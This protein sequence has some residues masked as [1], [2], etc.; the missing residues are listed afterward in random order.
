[1]MTAEVQERLDP[2][3]RRCREA[4][5][6]LHSTVAALRQDGATWVQIGV[7]LGVTPQAVQQRF[8]AS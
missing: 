7:V 1:M 2:F 8:G 4:A 3:D 6:Q 5:D